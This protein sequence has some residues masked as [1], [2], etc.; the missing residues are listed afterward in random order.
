MLLF[1][2]SN[3]LQ[4]ILSNSLKNTKAHDYE[5]VSTTTP[6]KLLDVLFFLKNSTYSQ[7]NLLTDIAAYDRPEQEKRFTV[8]YNLLSVKYNTRFFLSLSVSELGSV[9]SITEL[10]P[11]AN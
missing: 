2:Y 1:K 5:I 4:T 8:V 3:Q 11:S 7:F 9:P 6:E 10:Y